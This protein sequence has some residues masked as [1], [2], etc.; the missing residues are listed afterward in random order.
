M[1]PNIDH[2]T[3]TTAVTVGAEA[4]ADNDEG[5]DE[6]VDDDDEEQQTANERTLIN[7]AILILQERLEFPWRTRNKI[8]KL[9]LQFLFY[10]FIMMEANA[11]HGDVFA[12]VIVGADAAA[13]HDEGADEAVDDDDEEQTA[14]QRRLIN[15]AIFI[16]QE[17]LEFPWQTRNKIVE[18]AQQFVDGVGEDIHDMITDTRST[19]EEGDEGLDSDR[20]TETEVEK[21][22]RYYPESLTQRGGEFGDFPCHCLPI[23]VDNTT[24]ECVVNVKAISFVYLFVRLAIEFN[25]FEEEERGGLLTEDDSGKTVLHCLMCCSHPSYGDDHQ[26]NGDTICLAVLLRLR[27]SGLFKKEDI[28]QYELVHKICKKINF[29]EQ[30]FHFL[31]EWCPESLLQIDEYRRLPLHW[32]ADNDQTFRVVLDAIFRYY[33]RWRGITVLFQK[34]IDDGNTTPFSKACRKITRNTATKI[35]EETLIRYSTTQPIN[36]PYALMSAAIDDIIH[37]GCLYF[38]TRRHPDA[39]LGMLRQ[40]SGTMISTSS[41][42]TNNQN[43]SN[44]TSNTATNTTDDTT[45]VIGDDASMNDNNN[46]LL[47]RNTRKR[48]RTNKNKL[49]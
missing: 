9:A 15:K 7:K 8:V 17:R 29:P 22:I 40:K 34:R 32:A 1:E 18:L 39:M 6:A 5:A 20:D 27:Q 45:T 33:P 25:S 41:T 36:I 2:D 31:T 46:V 28:Q 4:A 43:D 23:M 11:D 3:V 16:L 30:R 10:S 35:V 38:L 13:N 14:N 49:F 26:R 24:G 21:A 44:A 42:T 19:E 12:A 48:K 37:L 47:R